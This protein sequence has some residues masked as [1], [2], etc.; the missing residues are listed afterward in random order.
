MTRTN[1]SKLM[2]AA[3]LVFMIGMAAGCSRQTPQEPASPP[4]NEA[5]PGT[6]KDAPPAEYVPVS[7]PSIRGFESSAEYLVSGRIADELTEV[8]P[9]AVVTAFGSPPRWSPPAFEQP[10]PLATQT[11]D[12]E[13]RYQIRLNAPANLWLHIRKEGYASVYAY[14]PVRDPKTLARDFQLRPAKSAISGL[15]L[16]KK[17]VPVAGALVIANPPPVMLLADSIVPA[18]IG[19]LTDAG[20]KYAIEGLTD[21]DISAIASARGHF[22]GE[23]LIPLRAG[24]T[25]QVNFNLAAASAI[26]FPVKNALGEV[27]PYAVATAP[28]FVK[29]A[30][31]DLRGILE[32]SVPAELSPFDCTVTAEG[33]QPKTILV[34]PKAPPASCV[35]EDKAV[36]KGRILAESGEAVPG[37]IVTIWGTGASQTKFESAVM[38]DKAGRF[39]TPLS[40]PPVREIRVSASGFLDQRV[41][42]DSKKPPVPETIVRM[43]RVEAGIFGRVIDYRGFP[44]K[45][46]VLHLRRETA[47]AGSDLQR[48]FSVE[49]GR[50]SV[51]DVAPGVYTLIIQSVPASSAEDV[52]VLRN[53][54]IEIRKGFFLGEFIAQLPKPLY[55]K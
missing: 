19:C 52:E 35:L 53:E 46:F 33:Y 48:S 26:S 18:P 34:D 1:G 49:S 14:L 22:M 10:A 11:C 39:S 12:Q 3:W 43:K 50:F 4:A 47:P 15:V 51:T 17:D 38:A 16:D 21:G 55:K 30:G 5:Q 20:G 2:S 36:F 31:S 37:A 41:A 27:L 29:I 24:Q 42:L 44:V 40:Y 7:D 13:G 32:F 54:G 45:R 9:E 6:A 25:E 28:G 23:Q 8:I